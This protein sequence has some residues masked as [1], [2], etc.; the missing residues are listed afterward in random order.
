MRGLFRPTHSQASTMND[1]LPRPASVLVIEDDVDVRQVLAQVLTDEGYGVD[2]AEDGAAGL[3]KLQGGAR[4]SVIL[5]D[6]WMPRVD[7][8][9]FRSAQ[10]ARAETA[11]I[12][13]V[14]VTAG[15]VAPQEM[16]AL[17]LTYVLR[18]PPDLEILLRV[19][20]RLSSRTA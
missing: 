8:F 5:L 14:V 9:A 4:P 18:K 12:P 1:A 3:A 11:D 16:A 17:G 19:V 7:G 6:L 20:R 13:V 2:C 10:L 15:G